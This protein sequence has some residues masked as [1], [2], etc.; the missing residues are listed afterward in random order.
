MSV[1]RTVVRRLGKFGLLCAVLFVVGLLLAAMPGHRAPSSEP[2][3]AHGAELEPPETD[4]AAMPGT[5]LPNGKA[6][7]QNAAGKNTPG[8][9]LSRLR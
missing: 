1:C 2:F 5:V 9:A 8:P 3:E 4:R 6:R 7:D